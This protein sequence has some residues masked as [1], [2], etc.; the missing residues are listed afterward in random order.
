MHDFAI[1]VCLEIR[2]VVG[3]VASG[4]FD[5]LHCGYPVCMLHGPTPGYLG[6]A[7]VT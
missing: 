1:E 5:V 2:G 6:I 3:L 7:M 4:A